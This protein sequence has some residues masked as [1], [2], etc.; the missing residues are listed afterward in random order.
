MIRN[1][2]TPP[3]IAST[4][5][6]AITVALEKIRSPGRRR[7]PVAEARIPP[8]CVVVSVCASTQIE[9]EWRA[10]RR[11]AGPSGRTFGSLVRKS[12]VRS[13]ADRVDGRCV[14]LLDPG[15]DR[16]RAGVLLSQLLALVADDEVEVGL[17]EIGRLGRVVLRAAH[18]VGDQQ[19]RVGARVGRR[20]LDRV[21]EHILALAQ[22]RVLLRLVEVGGGTLSARGDVGVPDLDLGHAEVTG[23]ALIRVADRALA[24]LDGLYQPRGLGTG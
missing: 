3:R 12:T 2:A 18:Q 21:G 8:A 10:P 16:S 9:D 1:T 20:A 7:P 15:R 13:A 14:L 5:T 23:L 6:A 11:G 17:D 24:G 4:V 22:L 19:H